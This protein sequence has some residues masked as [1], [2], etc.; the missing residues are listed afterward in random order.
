MADQYGASTL[1]AAGDDDF[2][3]PLTHY[4]GSYLQAALNAQ[5][6]NKW[7]QLS[8]GKEVVRNVFTSDPE[9]VLF[10]ESALPALFVWRPI[11][12]HHTE[13]IADDYHVTVSTVRVYWLQAHDPTPKRERR[14]QMA[15][16][17]SKAAH[18]ALVEGRH[19][20]WI[21]N[22]DTDTTAATRGSLIMTWAGLIR[23]PEVR[24]ET[25]PVTM[26]RDGGD[27]VTYQAI[28]MSVKCTERLTRSVVGHSAL[29]DPS[30]VSAL[31]LTVDQDGNEV[32][33]LVPLP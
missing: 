6:G 5:L 32:K 30:I 20:A 16:V 21:V 33:S 13:K 22:S 27:P 3:D 10:N 9:D 17:L 24:S 28:V 26:Q 31:D 1:P 15:G 11:S 18:A 4:L 19:P 8:P 23:P 14:M 29:K 25:I 2:V 7:Q 12:E